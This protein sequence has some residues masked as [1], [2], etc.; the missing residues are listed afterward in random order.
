MVSG[1]SF[2]LLPLQCIQE[3]TVDG[4]T[5]DRFQIL[6]RVGGGSFGVTHK[7]NL[8]KI[9]SKISKKVPN[10]SDKFQVEKIFP[11]GRDLITKRTVVLKCENTEAKYPQLKQEKN[12]YVLCKKQCLGIA[13][14][15]VRYSE[16]ED[17]QFREDG[18][19]AACTG[20]FN[21]LIMD[22]LGRDIMDVFTYQRE[23]RKNFN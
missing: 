19:D 16:S 3:K 5:R 23:V 21:V 11:K 22:Q 12:V 18:V 1:T 8:K 7:V 20:W 6:E 17:L 9:I 15:F 2:T 10:V 13:P 14:N 4:T